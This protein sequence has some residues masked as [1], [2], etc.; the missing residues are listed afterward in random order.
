MKFTEPCPLCDS[1]KCTWDNT[2]Q[3]LK[4]SACDLIFKP[5]A[6]HLTLNDERHRYL[7][8]NNSESDSRYV[9]FLT[10]AIRA[11]T[12]RVAKGARGLDYGSGP[13]QVLSSLLNS[14]GYTCGYYDPIFSP[15]GINITEPLDFI[16][17]TEAAEHFFYPDKEFKK[18]FSQ[19]K[20]KGYFVLMTELYQNQT[21]LEN[22]YYTKD[23]THVCFYTPKTIEWIAGR[24][25]ADYEILSPR[26]IVFKR[27]RGLFLLTDTSTPKTINSL[28]HRH[29][30]KQ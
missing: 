14:Q 19:L 7:Q 30:N 10:P 28:L 24:F 18:I 17:S 9:E 25:Q 1:N 16:V 13:T 26:L 4:C 11:I 27:A 22:W 6:Q 2:A 15:E 12:E 29:F 23:P 3:F 8:H 5:K 21:P 20:P